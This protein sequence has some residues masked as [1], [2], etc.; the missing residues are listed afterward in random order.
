MPCPETPSIT[1]PHAHVP[2]PSIPY[3]IEGENRK[4]CT[5]VHCTSPTSG[6]GG[7]NNDRPLAGPVRATDMVSLFS[8]T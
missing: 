7:E 1:L 5:H 2:S 8:R 4:D 3:I 6:E